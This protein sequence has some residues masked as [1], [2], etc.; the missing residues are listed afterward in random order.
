MLLIPALG[1]QRQ[2][3]LCEFK[4]S[5]AYTLS[6][7]TASATQRNPVLKKKIKNALLLLA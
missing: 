6:S 1:R 2:V 3:D 5:L 7:R 4:A